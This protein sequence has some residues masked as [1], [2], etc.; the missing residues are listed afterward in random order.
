MKTKFLAT[1]LALASTMALVSCKSNDTVKTTPTTSS[2]S[3]HTEDP[4]DTKGDGEWYEEDE[5]HVSEEIKGAYNSGASGVFF[6]DATAAEKASVIGDVESWAKKN[7]ILGIPLFGDGGWLLYSTR[8]QSP[9]NKEYVA[10]YGFGILREGK[11]TSALDATQ[12]PNEDYR[13]FLH[14]SMSDADGKLNPYDTNNSTASGL[15]DYVRGSLYSQ[16]LVKDGN[17]GYKAQYEWYHSLAIGEPEPLDY[18]E[19]SKTATTWKVKVKTG[20]NS[21]L[22]FKTMS[23]AVIN[24]KEITSFNDKPVT[25]DD[26]IW[27]YRVQL[28]GK[29]Q[30]SYAPQ[31][32]KRFNGGEAYYSNTANTIVGSTEDDAAW[33]NV[34]IKK[35]DDETI[36]ITLKSAETATNFKLEVGVDICNEDFWKTVTGYGTSGFNPLAYGTSS[37]DGE[38][39]PADTLLSCG[40]YTLKTY[41][42]GTGSDNEIVFVRNDDW[43]DTK[44][45]NNDKYQIYQIPGI[46]IKINKAYGEA[47]GPETLYQDFK[48]GKVDSASIPAARK[49]EYSR[50]SPEV[51]V[52]GNSTITA[53]QV[54][55]CTTDRWNKIFGKEGSNWKNQNDYSYDEAKANAYTIKPVMSNSD[56]LDGLYFSIDR[57]TLADSL[58]VG[59]SSDWVGEAYLVDI[60]SGISYS[61]TAAHKRAVADWAPDTYG[62]NKGVAQ[63]KFESAMDQLVSEGK[64]VAGTEEKPTQITIALQIARESQRANWATK[65]KSYIE[66]AF[67]SVE[68]KKGFNLTVEL[69]TAPDKVGDVYGI[70][71]SGCYD[72]CWGGINGG[73]ADTLALF[74]CWLDDWVLGLQMGCGVSPNTV[75][76]DIHF[77]GYSFS[78]KAIFYAFEW[79]EPVVIKNGVFMGFP[80]DKS[81]SGDTSEEGAGSSD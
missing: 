9:L 17:G 22:K 60:D 34:G 48:A 2:N 10:N 44:N 73:Q 66:E 61:S 3:S 6:S 38:L 14:N 81:G 46:V 56:F 67:N 41:S 15:L 75:T 21:G 64:Y 35:I 36:Q 50:N 43:V 24:G 26:Y 11:I 72:L 12:E 29:N 54:N 42:A 55:S 65:V 13:Y 53:L 68:N 23:K 76:D 31:Y 74:G 37:T 63:Q 57:A 8:V 47:S 5:K 77:R 7:H 32:A 1:I 28:N 70:L 4:D 33:A 52:T 19:E 49:N 39:T 25:V 59:L 62:Y 20:A 27:G 51:Y 79:G 45:E 58:M 71:A 40:P 78:A 80:D 30:Y 18:D 69:P 16:R